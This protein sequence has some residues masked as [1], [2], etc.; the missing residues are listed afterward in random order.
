MDTHNINKK[1]MGT[2]LKWLK[3]IK[4]EPK[5]ESPQWL[6]EGKQK[7]QKQI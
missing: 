6:N 1:T 7:C 4:F 2:C 5:K 3:I